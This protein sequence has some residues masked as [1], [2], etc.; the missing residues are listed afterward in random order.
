[1]I[2]L[3]SQLRGLTEQ[4][5]KQIPGDVAATMGAA[6]A[7]LRA[8]GIA[9][10]ALRRGQRMPDFALPDA[11]GQIVD[12]ETLRRSGPL[13]VVFY[14]GNWCPYCNLALKALQERLPAIKAKGA[15]LVAISPETPDQSLTTR[16][17][18]ELAFPVLTDGGN[19]VARTF[20]LVFALDERLRPIYR[21]FGVDLAAHNGEASH[22]LPLP[23]TYVVARDGTV[24]DA[25]VEADYRERL[26][27]E[28]VLEWLDRVPAAG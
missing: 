26:A 3:K 24:I 21:S 19:R 10:R 27:P 22:E 9:D 25:F 28:T 7:A 16:E 17:K 6:T 11:T 13:V 4:F 20:G 18:N 8:S 5:Q 14:R 15:T 1:M 12:S 23:A 2:D